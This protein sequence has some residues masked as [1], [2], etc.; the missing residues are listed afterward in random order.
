[1][2]RKRSVA[3][4]EAHELAHQ[5][6]GDLVTTAWWDDIW[7]NE[8]FASWMANK[9]VNQYH[10][11]W[12]MNIAE[13]NGYQGAMETDSLVS[14]RKVRQQILSNDDIAN[15]FDNITY[16]KGSALLNMFE[17]YM[18][19]Q[20]FQQGV[21]R[22]L[23]RY[24]WRN[25]TSAEF[26]AELGGEDSSI[27]EAFSSFLDQAG[28]PIVTT[29][30]DCDGG[31]P[32]LELL[33]RRFLPVGSEGSS[34]Q[35]WEIPICVRYGTAAGDARECT[36]LKTKSTELTL[37]KASGCPGWVLANAGA[38]GYYRTAYK[39]NLLGALLQNNASELELPEKVGLIG[40]I[41]ALADG[42]QMPLGGA[43]AL[44]PNLVKDPNRQVITKT[45]QISTGLQDNLV[46]ERLLPKYR[47]YLAD[48]YGA[49]AHELGWK[50]APGED[51]D[52]RLLRPPVVNVVATEAR[53][54]ELLAKARTLAFAWL[55]D[56]KAVQPDM[57]G[58][59]LR[60]AAQDGD[61]ALFEAF[62]A[63]AKK[64]KDERT[65][66]QLLGAMGSFHDPEIVKIAMPIVL[67]DEFD[68]RESIDLIFGLSGWPKTRNMAY[69]F[70]KQ[71]F[72]ALVAKM[73]TDTGAYFPYVAGGYC[74]NEHRADVEAF[75]KGRSTKY[76]GGPR[77]LDQVLEG[78]SL[79]VARKNAQQA[80]VVEF[81]EK[82]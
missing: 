52:T 1:M 9:I 44:M 79:C 28:V 27:P 5:W 20:K 50:S 14:S 8:G 12:K 73:P 61:R 41:A 80:S 77:I 59:V 69:D 78:I 36:L 3:S 63:E 35:T 45:M 51:D 38:A 70:V 21:R 62:R 57:V 34:D 30:L 18:G 75:F 13:L 47:K 29:Q 58:V 49:R 32:R 31:Q 56:R 42:G 33:Q 15:A 11:E 68:N 64:A 76:T 46:P 43:L 66:E 26:L 19:P 72:D 23:A 6:S 48:L 7:L 40:D 10:P 74:D 81:L 25:A 82:Y 24:A 71:N 65:R 2:G 17:S 37:S 67:T 60:A 39:G 53:D 4:V 16:N 55:A 22:Y 54:P